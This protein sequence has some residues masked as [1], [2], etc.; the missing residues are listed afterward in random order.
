MNRAKMAARES[1][2]HQPPRLR[3]WDELQIIWLKNGG[4]RP[5]EPRVKIF[6]FSA[7]DFWVTLKVLYGATKDYR[8]LLP[9]VALYDHHVIDFDKG[10]FRKHW[11]SPQ[12]VE[13]QAELDRVLFEGISDLVQAGW[14]LHRTCAEFA[15]LC[16]IKAN[17]FDAAVKK[18]ENFYASRTAA[19]LQLESKL[20][21]QNSNAK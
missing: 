13:A 21:P 20:P 11:K 7:R 10:Q 3:R 15:A 16:P 4:N 18:L 2:K 19:R 6:P 9:L 12:E 17:S 1:E 8:F 5:E 14:S